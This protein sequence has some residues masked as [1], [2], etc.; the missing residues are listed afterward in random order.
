MNI[1]P[2]ISKDLEGQGDVR[3][4]ISQLRKQLVEAVAF[5]PSYDQR[6]CELVRINP[7]LWSDL[8]PETSY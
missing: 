8:N 3:P 1:F 5:L 6:Q 4:K 7:Q 2:E